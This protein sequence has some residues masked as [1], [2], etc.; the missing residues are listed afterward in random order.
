MRQCQ[1]GL[2]TVL[3]K[4]YQIQEEAESQFNGVEI[5]KSDFL[6]WWLLIMI[7]VKHYEKRACFWYHFLC[8]VSNPY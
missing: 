2:L 8:T 4:W 3:K 6:R 7:D 5:L 1:Y